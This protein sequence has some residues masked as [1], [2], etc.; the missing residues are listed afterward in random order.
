M[1]IFIALIGVLGKRL[2]RWRTR[3]PAEAGAVSDLQHNLRPTVDDPAERAGS[4]EI[5]D[6]CCNQRNWRI[7]RRCSDFQL[8][9]STVA[10]QQNQSLV[11]KSSKSLAAVAP[12][13][14]YGALA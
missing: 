2:V 13:A 4:R 14:F 10:N 5:A 7:M 8:V 12:R 1:K 3:F 6:S 11:M 9:R